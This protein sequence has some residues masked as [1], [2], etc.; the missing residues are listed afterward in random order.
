MY[1]RHPTLPSDSMPPVLFDLDD[2]DQRL[3]TTARELDAVGLHEAAARERARKSGKLSEERH[4]RN[5]KVVTNR[6]SVGDHV[7]L[8]DPTAFKFEPRWYG[9][10][11][12]RD[13]YPE[14]D[15][16]QLTFPS[17]QLHPTRIHADML[18]LAKLEQPT[19]ELWYYKAHATDVTYVVALNL[20]GQ[21]P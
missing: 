4:A 5:N 3:E 12:I 16:Y 10:F 21:S 13:C 2:P 20:A 17:G 7:L 6:F 11:T 14:F 15:S 9:P 1:G 18:K 19:K 8:R